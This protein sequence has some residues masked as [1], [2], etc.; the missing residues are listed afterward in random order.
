[1]KPDN[2][3][4]NFLIQV[5]RKRVQTFLVQ[6]FYSLLAFLTGS[7]LAATLVSYFFPQVQ[8]YGG[9]FLT[10]LALALIYL[11]YKVF[12][13]DRGFRFSLDQAALLT[14]EKYPRLNNSLINSWQLGGQLQKAE[15]ERQISFS[16]IRE[17]MRRT[18]CLIDKI[19]PHSVVD[20]SARTQ[21]RNRL[22]AVVAVLLLA[23][24]AVP[25]LLTRGV[26]NWLHPAGQSVAEVTEDSGEKARQK[27]KG[28]VPYTIDKLALT[29][30]YPA[31]TN[32]ETVVVDPSDGKIEVLPGTEVHIEAKT[33]QAMETA[34]LL[35]N[36][37]DAFSMKL[38]EPAQMEA[39]F[40]VKE[41]GFYQ[42]RLK[43]RSGEKT[44]LPDKYPI[45]LAEDLAPRIIL[46]LAN[47]KPV[48][49]EDD[50]I[51][52][53][54][55]GHD[56]FGIRSIDLVFFVNGRQ[57]RQSIKNLKGNRRDSKGSYAWSLL[58]T[59][60]NPG[61]EVQYFLEIQDN[62]NVYGPNTGQSETYTFT[63]FD[64]REERENLILLQEELTEKLIAQLGK[65]LVEGDALKK[66]PGDIVRWRGLLT[67]SA[68][69]LID[70]IT[71]TQSIREQAQ[72]LNH[73]PRPYLNF[74]Q[75]LITGLTRVR[76]EQIDAIKKINSTYLKSTPVSYNADPIE[77]LNERVIRQLETGILFLV[78]MTNRQKMDQVMDLQRYLDE[79]TQSLREEF[80]KIQNMKAKLMP[81]E[82]RAKIEQIRQTLQKIMDQLARQTQS[83]PDEFL[84][85][86]AFQ[87]L[88][89]EEFSASLD[90]IM[91]LVNQ[92]KIKEAMEELE[93]TARDLQTL[94]NQLNNSMES[95]DDLVDLETME[96]LDD[97]AERLE[98]LE[99]RQRQLLEESTKINQS[100]R[101]A[102]SKRFSG[103]IEN[104]FD[105][106]KKDVNQIQS[107]FRGDEQYLE[108]HP[109]MKQLEELLDRESKVRGKIKE[110]GQKTVDSSLGPD[111]GDNFQKLNEQR[112]GL[113]RLNNEIDSLRVRI[114][115]RFKAELPDLNRK[116]DTLEELAELYELNEFNS[117]FKNVYPEVFHWQ[118]NLRTSRN[119]REGI[120]DRMDNDLRQVTALNGEISKK[121]GS[122]MRT[123]RE[124][125][126]FLLTEENKKELDSM[127]QRENRLRQDADG[128]TQ[129]FSR[130]NQQ[131]PLIT[132]ELAAKMA[133]TGRHM[134]R[135]QSNLKEHNIKKS[136]SS[137]NSALE[138]IQQTR[139]LLE[140]IRNTN[141]QMARKSQRSSPLKLGSGSARDP[142]R[143]GSIRMQKE[144][145]HLPSEDQYKVPREFREEIL[146]AMKKHTPKDY[147]RMVME[148]YKE[149]VK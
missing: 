80:D 111:I 50:K 59:K 45:T 131:N 3:I 121:L 84:N 92:G 14:E 25:D 15:M 81:N 41:K 74:L 53:F 78:K 146:K 110:L 97:S 127:A 23:H 58:G 145:V 140:E 65:N 12:F 19:Q 63:I 123:I 134:K 8:A 133:R 149:L 2:R 94:A 16:F 33:N 139:E 83:M 61:D 62:D 39:R 56:D 130:M 82:L 46:F 106:L 119:K 143:G 57:A 51:H 90:R 18:Q 28:P 116:Y 142:R 1:M 115:L 49:F 69:N 98:Q 109:V 104:M 122:M 27:P 13:Q 113:S 11:L 4:Q 91:D 70:I 147:Q 38:K 5:R 118:N 32:L 22:F 17:H 47:P 76:E 73:F 29:Y 128:L 72:V 86:S 137:E 135:A 66:T 10:L 89:M 105:E 85:P 117:L 96:L 120:G 48:Y 9:F 87:N 136:I 148:Y 43:D 101:R 36:G 40:L 138:E 68:D 60:L 54:Y 112:R 67:S 75:N 114:F 64:S 88:N 144:K 107:I 42:F 108:D 103:R 77:S 79:L 129:R 126:Q 141:N 7:V 102:Q 71:L 93:K 44:L 26:G 52:F 35:L 37:K 6:G 31:Y 124:S 132:P 125:D 21:G 30:H 55:E 100:L 95:M 20:T 24:W 99:N 34:E